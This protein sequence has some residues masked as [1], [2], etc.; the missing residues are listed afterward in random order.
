MKQKSPLKQD[1]KMLGALLGDTIKTQVGQEFFDKLENIRLLSKRARKN[2]DEAA[3]KE[4][5]DL[6][7]GLSNEELKNLVRAFGQF[8]NLANLAEAHHFMSDMKDFEEGALTKHLTKLT[9]II[10]ELLANGRSKE[11]II[12]TIAG[13][14][15]ELVMTAHPT[16]VKRRTWLHKHAQINTL[17]DQ[18]ENYR[19]TPSEQKDNINRI[20]VLITSLWESD[21][22]RRVRPTPFEEAKWGLAIIEDTVWDAVPRFMLELDAIVESFT[23]E[24]L[25]TWA[26]P[27][28]FA[29][30]MGGDRD[31]NPNVTHETTEQV[32]LRNR[33][34][35]SD[36][37][38]KEVNK[39]IQRISETDCSAEL[40]AIVGD[41]H[42]PYRVFLRPFRARFLETK[43]W[44]QAQLEGKS[45]EPQL[46]LM[47]DINEFLDALH[48]CHRSLVE[49]SGKDLADAS[50]LK[51]IRR[52]SCFG[53]NILKLDV[54][55]E[56]TRHS[57]VINA[58]TE[59]LELGSYDEWDEA[60][61]QEFLVR[62]LKS[63]RPLLPRDIQ[64]DADCQEVVDTVKTIAKQPEEALGAYVISMSRAA[65]DVLAVH[66]LQKECGVKKPLRV[67][68]LFETLEDLENSGEIMDTLF[69]ID[70]YKGAS[71]GE[72]EVMI[73]YSDSGKDA[74]KLAASWAQ[75]TAQEALH[76]VSE[77]HGIKLTLFHGRGGSVGRGGGPVEHA[78]MSQPPGTVDGRMRV[79]EQG[80]VLQAKY[81]TIDV[82]CHNLLLY[83]TA[84]L[85]ATL[86]KPPVPK[87]E[88]RELMDKM[89]VIS[90]DAYRDIV[91]GRENFVKY[92]RQVT[93]E[94]ELGRLHIGSRPAKR[95]KSGGIESLR[96]IPWIFAW[97]QIRL[98][99]P[100]WLGVGEALKVA[101]E[102]GKH[103][104]LQE[105]IQDWPFFYF[106]MDMIDMV[107]VKTDHRVAK[108]YDEILAD[109]DVKELG[110]ELRTKLKQTLETSQKVVAG[111]STQEERV[112]LRASI[113]VRNPYADTLNY[114]QGECMR[115]LYKEN[116]DGDPVLEDAVMATIAG[117]AAAMK[118][119][120]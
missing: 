78:L 48:I 61:K 68:P 62:E 57:D 105:M 92:F 40:R 42:E 109:D 86:A 100:S 34:T 22:I 85:Q 28:K 45:Y 79:T 108:Y 27:I 66:L 97:T 18:K 9:Q 5:K 59:H 41:V 93:P 2:D 10:P 83:V 99:L 37:Y 6:I 67:A 77:K 55:Q 119:T 75:Y 63:K 115:R 52:A 80:E 112:A 43:K 46:P 95:K 3:D 24:K 25:P 101:L 69:G 19:M 8:L 64:F 107:M 114:L 98:M 104:Q 60:K 116:Q 81:S 58:I 82:A 16:E 31:G 117:I 73:G 54:R 26:A 47:E 90:C 71:H 118:N 102:D 56:S 88:W 91:R 84:V 44:T 111:L 110:L 74:G 120:G 14:N 23:G 106:L 50:V 113:K 49:C 53:L 103:D 72:Q 1:I 33:W 65:S 89:S 20:A 7:R 38:H 96:A 36:L 17:L 21:E 32:C 76:Q 12:N 51:I 30:W 13:M 15:I 94:Q 70:W 39:A 11:E 29:S 35:A 87:P 4:L